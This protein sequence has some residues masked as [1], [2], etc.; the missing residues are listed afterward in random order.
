MS[1]HE[2]IDA[3]SYNKT[4]GTSLHII[5]IHTAPFSFQVRCSHIDIVPAV[6]CFIVMSYFQNEKHMVHKRG[7]KVTSGV[8][9][10]VCLV[11]KQNVF[12]VSTSVSLEVSTLRVSQLGDMLF[13]LQSA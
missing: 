4:E 6:H 2:T 13:K 9:S 8:D 11:I 1:H 7:G 10:R 12:K 5:V 3:G